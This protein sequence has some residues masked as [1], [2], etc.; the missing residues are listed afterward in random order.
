MTWDP[1]WRHSAFGDI[2]SAVATICEVTPLA[3]IGPSK[4]AEVARPR[5]VAVALCERRLNMSIIGLA[6]IFGRDRTSIRN[7]LAKVRDDSGLQRLMAKAEELLTF[8]EEADAILASSRPDHQL[9]LSPMDADHGWI[10]AHSG[11][12]VNLLRPQPEEIHL[13]DIAWH[14]S[15]QNRW[16]GSLSQPFSVAAHSILVAMHVDP[17]FG[18]AALLHDAAEAYF[19]DWPR[20]LKHDSASPVRAGLRVLEHNMEA[21]IGKRFGVSL[22]PKHPAIRRADRQAMI[23]ELRALHPAWAQASVR[24]HWAH[25]WPDLEPLPGFE[26]KQDLDSA[27][28]TGDPVHVYRLFKAVAFKLVSPPLG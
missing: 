12:R 11:Q 4:R 19:G 25:A 16:A 27:G 8:G 22:S 5:H 10:T 26:T 23:T 13:D 24:S 9:P 7:S 15:Q 2:I 21:A 28:L 6:R 18:L 14:L 17:E 3:V 1:N 20:P